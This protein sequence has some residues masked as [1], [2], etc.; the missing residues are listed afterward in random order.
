[1]SDIRIGNINTTYGN[2]SPIN[3]TQQTP[4]DPRML[5]RDLIRTVQQMQDEVR[6]TD[7]QAV[8]EFL[9]LATSLNVKSPDEVD[10]NRL[11]EA[12]QKL[13]GVATMVG[14]VGV[15]VIEAI[16]GLK[17]ALGLLWSR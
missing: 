7:R 16:R 12:L 9:E 6:G 17:D 8:V 10:K 4:V 5:I 14:Q 1:M 2:F 13:A 11:R 15:P 3:V